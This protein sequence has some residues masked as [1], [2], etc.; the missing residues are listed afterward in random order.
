M[1]GGNI[2]CGEF[3][4]NDKSGSALSGVLDNLLE[5][6]KKEKLIEVIRQL[7]SSMEEGEDHLL[8][9]PELAAILLPAVN[10]YHKK[11]KTELGDVDPA[12]IIELDDTDDVDPVEAKWGTGKGWQF[13]C[14]TDLIKALKESKK[15]E[16]PVVIVFD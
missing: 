11:L 12:S 1:S 8:I 7:Q 9:D 2:M 16:E 13:Y 5:L 14:T 3:V 15:I 6:A 10:A 4:G